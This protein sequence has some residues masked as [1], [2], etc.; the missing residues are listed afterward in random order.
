[1]GITLDTINA[2]FHS[3]A[4]SDGTNTLAVDANGKISIA[5]IATITGSVTV[6]DGG[7]SLTVD[8]TVG[9]SGTVAVTQSGTWSN[10][11]TDGTD[12]LAINS[13]GSLNVQAAE[14][15][16]ADWAVAAVSVASTATQIGAT[17]LTGRLKCVIQNLGSQDIFIGKANTVTTANGLKIPKGSSQE[18][19][20]DAGATIWGIT[21]SSTSDVRFAE[22][23]A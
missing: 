16:Y 23:K 8:G 15:G 13:D 3:I 22:Y 2:G 21:A 6:V 14:A 5:D 18:I 9:I 19:G 7:G 4:I 17:P 11:I 12:T 20:L 10:Q 1:M